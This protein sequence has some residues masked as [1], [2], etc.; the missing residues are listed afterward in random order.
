MPAIQDALSRLEPGQSLRLIAP[1][2]PVP[3]YDFLAQRG[4]TH[5]ATETEPGL[6]TVLFIPETA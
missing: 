6:W 1:F 4:F 5:E 3:L 2:E